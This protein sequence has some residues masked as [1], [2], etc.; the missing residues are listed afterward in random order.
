MGPSS[1]ASGEKG[2]TLAGTLV[3]G[4]ICAC[5]VYIIDCGMIGAVEQANRA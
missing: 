2:I 4:I 3:V 1:G 5:V